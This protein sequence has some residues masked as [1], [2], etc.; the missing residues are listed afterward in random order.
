VQNTGASNYTLSGG[1]VSGATA[2]TVSLVLRGIGTTTNYIYSPISNG[3]GSMLSIQ[4]NGSNVWVLGNSANS[5]TGPTNIS[6]GFLGIAADYATSTGTLV[7]SSNRNGVRLISY[8]NHT[9]SN[10]FDFGG[11]FT[12]NGIGG[13][14]NGLSF[15]YS[16]SLARTQE[17]YALRRSHRP[18]QG[19]RAVM[20]PNNSHRDTSCCA[21][22]YS[23]RIISTL[24]ACSWSGYL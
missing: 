16:T 20:W 10:R 23:D 1:S 8:G 14:R 12:F 24:L 4:K 18:R 3:A 17:F 21:P 22:H 15:G 9:L 19:D 6:Q 5:Y 11:T 13:E 7:V 2:G